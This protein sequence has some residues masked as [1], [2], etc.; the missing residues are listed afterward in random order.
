ME[1][2]DS[3]LPLYVDL[4]GTYIKTD[5]LF[6][7][8]IS[9]VKSNP[10]VLIFCFF[11]VCK[12]KAYL[13]Y[14]LSV[15]ADI[16]T[17][18]MPLSPEFS[19]FLSKE[20]KSGRKIVLATA[21]TEKYAKQIVENS[22]LFD[23]YICSTLS[24]NL[25]GQKKL[26]KIKEISESFSYAGNDFSDFDIFNEAIESFLVNPS[27]SVLKKIK[28]NN[29]TRIFDA[30]RPKNLM[31]WFKQLRIHQWL[32]NTL[33]FVPLLVSG[34][35]FNLNNIITSF[36]A[37][38]SFSFLASATYIFN[39]LLDLEADRS[40]PRKK[41][42]PLASGKISIFNAIIASVMLILFSL[43]IALSTSNY[44]S[45]I[46]LIYLI[47]TLTYSFKIK[48]YIGMDVIML[49]L[50]YTVRIIAGA[51]VLGIH[52]S[53]WLLAFSIFIFLSLALVKRCSEINFMQNIGKTRSNGRDYTVSDYAILES[54]G[55]STAMLAVLTICFYINNNALTNQYQDPD[56]LWSIIPAVCYWLMRMWIK[57]HRGEMY[58]DP[59]V[60]SLTDK[61][62]LIT[63]GFCCVIT[64][65]AQII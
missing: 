38:I 2:I 9:A 35:F 19:K 55:T 21:S 25:K 60:F 31:Y 47:L 58:D 7:S 6:E 33:I 61:G 27:P 62:S 17:N 49:A 26:K 34:M 53:F 54:F 14:K 48:Q 18:F 64:L 30:P 22:N 51:A 65:V 3:V 37:F 8:L 13:K 23:G 36:S 50:L 5:L 46:L 40:H 45:L 4:D 1:S 44:F 28:N 63:I 43:I 42:R 16:N 24:E 12:G 56:I 15:I 20:K 41:E 32:K 57:T 39:D 11:W 29:I 52:A 59:I 10:F